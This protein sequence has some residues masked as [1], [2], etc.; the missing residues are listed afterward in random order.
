MVGY[1]TADGHPIYIDTVHTVAN[2]PTCWTTEVKAG[3][4]SWA[5]SVYTAEFKEAVY[6]I[7]TFQRQ[8]K[9]GITTPQED[10]D[11]IVQRIKALRK[12]RE[13]PAAKAYIAELL[14]RHARRQR[15]ID[16]RRRKQHEPK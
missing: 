14:A 13:E 11:R 10:I 7:D 5:I 6:A 3:E 2:P 8:S 15:I 4:R 12:E 9:R 16:E 1:A